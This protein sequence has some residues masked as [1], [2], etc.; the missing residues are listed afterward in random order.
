MSKKKFFYNKDQIMPIITQGKFYAIEVDKNGN[1]LKDA[2]FSSVNID[3][4]SSLHVVDEK[5]NSKEA[6]LAFNLEGK[7]TVTITGFTKD[8]VRYDYT[9]TQYGETFKADLS[10]EQHDKFQSICKHLEASGFITDDKP[11]GLAHAKLIIGL[12]L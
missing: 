5:L 4:S 2:E 10:Q 6:V 3:L 9:F 8:V 11:L 7:K 12:C 1:T